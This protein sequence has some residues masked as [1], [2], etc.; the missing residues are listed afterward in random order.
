MQY[1]AKLEN[2]LLFVGK[3]LYK[4]EEIAVIKSQSFADVYN[5]LISKGAKNEDIKG[6]DDLSFGKVVGE[7]R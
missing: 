2:N 4:R 5:F 6:L 3:V 1:T 7:L